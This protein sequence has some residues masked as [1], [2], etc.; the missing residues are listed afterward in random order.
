MLPKDIPHLPDS[1]GASNKEFV[2]DSAEANSTFGGLTSIPELLGTS[3][4]PTASIIIL[5]G[6]GT[7]SVQGSTC[8]TNVEA[9]KKLLTFI[10][11]QS[12]AAQ[13]SR[14]EAGKLSS[15]K[16]TECDW[17]SVG[18]CLFDSALNG[19]S[20]IPCQVSGCNV[21]IHHAC[22]AEWENGGPG[23]ET[24]GCN[25]LNLSSIKEDRFHNK[26][27]QEIIQDN[28]LVLIKYCLKQNEDMAWKLFGTK[29]KKNRQLGWQVG[30]LENLW[31]ASV[32]YVSKFNSGIFSLYKDYQDTYKGGKRKESMWIHHFV[33]LQLFHPKFLKIE[34]AEFLHDNYSSF[35][36][37]FTT[38][39]Q[40]EYTDICE[41]VPN[42]NWLWLGR[43][44]SN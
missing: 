34:S 44:V 7:T 28:Q 1:P 19:P 2:S 43:N 29:N 11:E 13:A 4:M 37:Q 30:E 23:R 38:D 33:S 20:L 3:E 10:V 18:A 22:Q 6:A 14:L 42:Y 35:V 9:H 24:G 39:N 27:E 15:V 36:C 17:L 5:H 16:N 12:A 21:L 32:R 31:S 40:Q 41:D 25:K 8:R 26:S